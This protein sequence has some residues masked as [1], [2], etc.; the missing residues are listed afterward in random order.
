MAG[1]APQLYMEYPQPEQEAAIA[2]K[3]I[4]LMK[5]Q[6]EKNSVP[7]KMLRDVHSKSHAC[8]KGQFIIE[9]NL[10]AD[11]GVGLF[12]TPKTYPCW[13]RYSNAGGL[14]PVGGTAPDF[15]RDARGMAIKLLR[16]EGRKLLPDEIDA[17][18]QDFLLFTPN[19]FFTADP[20]GFYNLMVA[21]TT[22]PF[23][24]AWFLIKNPKVFIA[25]FNSLKR[26]GSL[27]GLQYF[28]AVPYAF[29]DKAVKYSA[30]PTNHQP[31]MPPIPPPE[32]FLRERLK[33]DLAK[34]EARF[35]FMV[36]FQTDPYKMPIENAIVPWDEKL[37]P[38]RKVATVV[39]P[40]QTFDSPEQMACCEN[41]S[42]TPWHC[43]TEH[44]P[45]GSVSRTRKLVYNAISRFRHD[46]NHQP[47]RE[48]VGDNPC[49]GR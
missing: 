13:I 46:Q 44:R 22:S 23:A 20:E 34:G 26:H 27:L 25:L 49:P 21:L 1:P 32:N 8:V 29:G 38:F 3:I 17:T 14:A 12:A 15:R 30:R 41:S 6:M 45:L 7:G 19:V 35:D 37:S 43:L 16:V 5:G 47:R 39:I 40:P 11:L 33:E 18:T 42:F 28:S 48:P 2:D 9:P 31:A 10:P 24:L 36:Q 4:T